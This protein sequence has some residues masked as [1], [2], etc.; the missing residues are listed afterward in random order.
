MSSVRRFRCAGVAA[1]ARTGYAP[2]SPRPEHTDEAHFHRARLPG[3]QA[4]AVRHVR[5]SAQGPVRDRPR[6][7]RGQG[8]A[9]AGRRDRRRTSTTS[10]SATW[11]RPAPTPSTWRATSGCARACRWPSPALTVNRLCGSGFQAVVERRAQILAR[12]RRGACWSAAPSRC[13]QAPHVMRGARWGLPLGKA[14]PLE[15]TLWDGA[16]RQL[17]RPADGDDR[18]EPGG[19]STASSQDEVDEYARALAEALRR[20]R[21]RR[22]RFAEEIAPIELHD[23]QGRQVQFARTSTRAR[24]H[25]RRRCAKL[26]KVFKKDGVVHAGA[27]SGHLRRR[28]R[29]GAGHARGRG[30][31]G[32]EAARRGSS[33][34]A[35]PAAI[36]RSWASGRCRRSGTRSSAPRRSSPDFDLFEVNEAFAP[37][38][39]AVEKE[40]GLAAR[41]H[42][43]RR[44]RDRGRPPARRLGRAHHRAPALRARRR[45]ARRG[46][47]SACIGGGQG[48]AVLLEA[49]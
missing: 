25:R 42:Q 9:G 31:H 11:C 7:P 32:P 38:Y 22:A 18:R 30:A 15:D 16:H 23:Q 33:A 10:S 44:R 41:A 24:H 14:P 49:A 6:R 8:G 17:R 36:R 21:R 39:L 47:G 48:I 34:G 45:G 40:L 3:R 35:S 2:I 46:I 5:R 43:R 13:R 29:A 37:Q 4:H 28:R 26:P 20:R 1:T 19:R 12:R 27:A